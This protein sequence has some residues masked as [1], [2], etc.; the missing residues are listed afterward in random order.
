[1]MAVQYL[2]QQK[3]PR[4]TVSHD[5]RVCY[6]IY[7]KGSIKIIFGTGVVLASNIYGLYEWIERR[8]LHAEMQ[9]AGKLTDTGVITSTPPLREEGSRGTVLGTESVIECI[10]YSI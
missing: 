8:R 4:W 6:H 7:F 3:L 9:R 1:M 5:L 10:V 2:A